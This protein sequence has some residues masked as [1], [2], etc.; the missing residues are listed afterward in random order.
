MK[1]KVSYTDDRELKEIIKRLDPVK[2]VRVQPAKGQYKRAYME[3]VVKP[4]ET[5]RNKDLACIM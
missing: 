5:T 4:E 1:I 2:N 3:A